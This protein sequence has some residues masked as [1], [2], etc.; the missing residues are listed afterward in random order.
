MNNNRGLT[1]TELLIAGML[2]GIAV[3]GM[4]GI[5]QS[6]RRSHEG[7][8]MRMDNVARLAAGLKQLSGDLRNAQGSGIREF[9]TGEIFTIDAGMSAQ[10]DALLYYPYSSTAMTINVTSGGTAKGYSLNTVFIIRQEQRDPTG[11]VTGD[12]NDPA[13]DQYVMYGIA[14][15]S[16][17]LQRW[18]FL[19]AAFAERTSD[20]RDIAALSDPDIFT[21]HTSGTGELDFV[22]FNLT[23]RPDL[24][25][26]FDPIINPEYSLTTSV[27]PPGISR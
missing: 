11:A 7:S 27:N 6:I 26:P 8:R 5:D 24:S 25:E 20:P 13:D 21:V 3:L 15:G 12:I 22:E 9:V 1:L 14:A 23:T 2:V 4:V 16:N 10:S 18:V 19:P 17:Q